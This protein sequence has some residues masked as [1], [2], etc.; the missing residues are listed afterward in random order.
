VAG[1]S[2]GATLVGNKIIY[3]TDCGVEA[4][5]FLGTN[6]NNYFNNTVN[7]KFGDY[8]DTYFWNTTLVAGTNIIGGSMR[9]RLSEES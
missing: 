7:R 5:G 6:Y 8:E 9:L 1:E 3:C 4:T 2:G